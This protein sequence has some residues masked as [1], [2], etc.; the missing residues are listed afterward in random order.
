MEALG[1]LGPDALEGT[2]RRIVRIASALFSERSYLGVSMSDIAHGLGMSKP[3]LYYHFPSKL[4]LYSRVLDEVLAELRAAMTEVAGAGTAIVQLR[5]FVKR[6]L[7]FGMQERNL[8]N[9]VVVRGS[10]DHAEWS[11]RVAVFRQEI[12][13]QVEP[14]VGESIAVSRLPTGTDTVILTKML[15]ALMDGLLFDY[16][17]FEEPIDSEEVAGRVLMTLGLCETRPAAGRV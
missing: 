8:V 5:R 2:K 16:S 4:D 17:C 13:D 14:I 7:D 11:R 10:P 1:R 9:A 3:A 6:Y 15:M 12:V